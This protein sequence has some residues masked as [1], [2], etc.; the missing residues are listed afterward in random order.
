MP[1]VAGVD[2]S[3]Q[4]TKVE[5]RDADSGA[6][7]GAGRAPHPDSRAASDPAV[8]EQD[9]AAWR[10]AFDT[11]WAAALDAAGAAAA[12][13]AAVSV[14]GQQHGCVVLDA[15]GAPVRP[16]KLWNDTSTAADA[17]LLLGRLPGGA[18]AWAHACGS[19]PVAAFTIAKLAWL[20]RCEP[21]HWARIAAV[22]LPHDWLTLQLTGRLVTDRGDASGTGWWSPAEE[23]YRLDLPALIDPDLD[24]AAVLPQVLGPV[25]PAGEWPTAGGSVLVGPGTGDN[26]AAALGLGAGPGEVVVSIGTSGTIYTVADHPT[27]DASGAVAGFADATGRYLPLVCTLNAAK[28]TD[29][30]ARLLAVDQAGLDRLALAAPWDP[31]GSATAGPVLLPYLDGERTPD[32]PRA[33]GVLT[34]IR[35]DVTREQLARAA[36]SGVVCGL[37]DGLDALARHAV[38]D[39]D[40]L[41]L[42][43]GG[44]RSAAY[45]RLLA[46]LSQRTV[47]T[48]DL[49]ETVA[50]GAA[51][52][53]AA[54]L[55]RR[56][57]EDVRAAWTVGTEQTTEPSAPADLA[58]EVRGRYAELRDAT[59]PD[60]GAP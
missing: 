46:D 59:N 29:A 22:C 12:D 50:T 33:S 35:S 37:L 10:V 45:R 28:V 43:G 15:A 3:T 23:R 18:A 44:A 58:A 40:R 39:D 17:A 6:L 1:L 47:V 13:V 27:A 19:V 30:V 26:M 57:P 49:D 25:E 14:A 42:V 24:W 9:P 20:R 31:A 60:T 21:D 2:S 48:T 8:S 53:A 55:H 7:V 32:R 41:V 52:Q 54:T 36:F 34:G 11:A 38:V 4:S 5:F 56:P 51:V 16:A